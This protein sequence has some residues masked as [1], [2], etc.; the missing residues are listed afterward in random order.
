MM[1]QGELEDERRA[2]KPQG[3][4]DRQAQLDLAFQRITAADAASDEGKSKAQVIFTCPLI[5]S[6]GACHG[7]LHVIVCAELAGS[8]RLLLLAAVYL[9][10]CVS[11]C[12]LM[13]C[14]GLLTSDG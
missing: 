1:L 14:C 13:R 7:F 4:H 8:C 9:S 10:V 6:L 3:Q 5:P 12:L 2:R 11:V